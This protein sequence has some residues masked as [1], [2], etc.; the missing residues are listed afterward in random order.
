MSVFSGLDSNLFSKIL[1]GLEDD[2]LRSI[3]RRDPHLPGTTN[4]LESGINSQIRTHLKLHRGMT[5]EYQIVLVN[6]YLYTRTEEQ[7]APR[8]CL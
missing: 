5:N 8:F 6:C 3:Y 4:H 7:K 2:L 1:I